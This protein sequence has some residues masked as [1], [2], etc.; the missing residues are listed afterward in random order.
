MRQRSRKKAKRQQSERSAIIDLNPV[1]TELFQDLSI[2]L[3]SDHLSN[4]CQPFPVV[5]PRVQDSVEY[6]V[7]VVSDD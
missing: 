1:N 4:G 7:G 3:S 6:L 2:H 5:Q